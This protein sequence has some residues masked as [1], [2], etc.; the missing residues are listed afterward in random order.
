MA[1]SPSLPSERAWRTP[2]GRPLP[3]EFFRFFRDLLDSIQQTD[4][5]TAE[6][7]ALIARVT[8][9]EESG[10]TIGDLLG[11]QSVQVFGSLADGE[12]L[13]RLVNDVATPG[14]TQYYGTD[15]LGA[16]GYRAVADTIE[17]AAGELTKTVGADGVTS[18]GLADVPNG[19]DG[20]FL[21]F[22]RD[23][24]GR[25]VSTTPGTSDDVP[26]GATNLYFTDERAQDAVVV[27]TITNGDTTHAPSGDAV[28]DALAGKEPTI[29]A[30]TTAQLWRGDKTWSNNIL[31]NFGVGTAT[32]GIIGNGRELS[33][34]VDS[35]VNTLARLNLQGNRNTATGN[36]ASLTMYNAAVP[37]AQMTAGCDG[38]IDAGAFS[39]TTKPTG[40]ALA[41][42]MSFLS[43]GPVVAGADNV[44]TFGSASL[45]WS[46]I[47]AGNGAIN[48]SDAREKFQPREL[49]PQE[50]ACASDLALLPRIY[51]WNDAV[52]LKGAEAARLHCSPVVQDV[53]AAMQAHGL[54][55]F[56]YG[57]VCYD[58]WGELPEIRDEETGEIVQE[59]RPAGDRYSLRPDELLFFIARGQEERLR[60][61]E[62][63]LN[64]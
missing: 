18:F 32:P 14:V 44:Q 36:I 54:N 19:G 25:V 51:Q 31:G 48:T 45:R 16:K 11:D 39:I 3:V 47:Y 58:Q 1:D 38:A 50:L 52:E 41:V 49:T 7:S 55:P 4:G 15:A 64:P 17:A 43:S 35:A 56:R 6:L 62:A 61:I 37:I 34:S 40:G 12:A 59:Y 22:Y 30:G 46:E 5:N 33:V 42:R 9:L 24:K 63:I 20:A 27:Q 53:I 60:R 8:A 29:A 23:A 28:F 10:G 2:D 13:L 21:L 57:F 26:E